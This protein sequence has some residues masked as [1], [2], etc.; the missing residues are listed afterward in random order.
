MP[1]KNNQSLFNNTHSFYNFLKA[2]YPNIIQFMS[3]YDWALTFAECDINSVT[4]IFMDAIHSSI[5]QFVTK[6][7]FTGSRFSGLAS[8]ELQQLV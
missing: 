3:A 5:L 7:N 6:V 8:K 1:W 4:N 2:N